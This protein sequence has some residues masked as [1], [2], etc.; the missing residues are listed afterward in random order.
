MINREIL[1]AGSNRSEELEKLMAL[2]SLKRVQAKC[3][4]ERVDYE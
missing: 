1:E 4:Y 2:W 3:A